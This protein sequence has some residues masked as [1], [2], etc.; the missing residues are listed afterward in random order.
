MALVK[1]DE[2]FNRGMKIVRGGGDFNEAERIFN[3]ILNED[4]DAEIVVYALGCCAIG[5]GNLGLAINL[6]KRALEIKDTFAEAWNNLGCCY[7]SLC[8]VEKARHAFERA[9]AIKNDPEFL[10]NLGGSYVGAGNPLKALHY[11][12]KCLE[13]MPDH[14]SS[15]NNKSLA[16]LEQGKWQEG[17]ALYDYRVATG[18]HKERH[19]HKNGTPEWDGTPGK[20]VVVYG[21]Q[22]IG[23]EIMFASVI[24]D[25]MKKCKVILDMHPR[26]ADLFRLAFPTLPVYGTRKT[27]VIP[28]ANLYDIDAKLSIGSLCK[29]FRF[30]DKDF[31]KKPYMKADAELSK[32]SRKMLE[33]YGDKPKIGISW[34]GGT[35]KTNKAYRTIP[36]KLWKSILGMDATFFSLQYQVEAEHELEKF[37]KEHPNVPRIHHFRDLLD[38]YDKTAA[39]VANLDLVISVPQSVVHLAGALGTPCWQLTPQ[40]AMWQM[41]VNGKDMPWYG[42]VNSYWQSEH[43]RWGDVL[44]RVSSDLRKLFVTKKPFPEKNK[45]VVNADYRGIQAAQYQAA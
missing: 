16:L 10:G 38:D 35:K 43:N 1:T 42:C 4:I 5:R 24:P 25:L 32:I 11:L 31:P 44:G 2:L 45:R 21:E 23:D 3:T 9:K 13:K 17:F 26:L 27:G 7:R 33:G 19:Y 6:F 37:N 20:T 34:K 18:N 22:G 8:F 28:W 36:L 41:G 29:F 30:T 39:L 12:S 40:R 15:L 14:P